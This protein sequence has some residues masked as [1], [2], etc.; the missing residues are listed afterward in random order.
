MFTGKILRIKDGDTYEIDFGGLP[1]TV[2]LAN[3]DVPEKNTPFGKQASKEVKELLEGKT[4]DFEVVRF[5]NCG[6]HLC[7]IYLEGERLDEILVAQGL[8]WHWEKYSNH[9]DL[10]EIEKQAYEQ[11]LGVWQPEIMEYFFGE[12]WK[13]AQTFVL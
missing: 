12:V 8:A 10:V 6:R 3:I 5:D 11:G 2:R 4:I 1:I 7:V 13:K 9:K